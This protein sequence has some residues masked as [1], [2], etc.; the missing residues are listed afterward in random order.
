MHENNLVS[1]NFKI[2]NIVETIGIGEHNSSMGYFLFKSSDY[3]F[4][5]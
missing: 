4:Y 2:K 1:I 3:L 5:F